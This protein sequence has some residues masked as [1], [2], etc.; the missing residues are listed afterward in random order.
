MIFQDA[1]SA[2][3]PVFTVGYQIGEMF[4]IHRG[5]SKPTPTSRR[6]S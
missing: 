5:M 2:L 3:N 4:R 6:S 1:L